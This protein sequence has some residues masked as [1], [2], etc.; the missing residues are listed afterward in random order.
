MATRSRRVEYVFDQRTTTLATATRLDHATETITIAETASRVFK[1]VIVDVRAS[2]NNA[3]VAATTACLIGIKLAAV[4]FD[5]VTYT[6]GNG[7]TADGYSMQYTRDVTSYFTT[8]FGSGTTQTCQVGTT[9]TGSGTIN[10]TVKLIITYEFD[11]SSATTRTKTVKIPLE[12]GLGALTTTLAEV[13]T[14]QVP[15]L[16]TFLP[17]AS[18]TVKSLWFEV[19]SNH[20]AGGTTDANLAL[21]LDAEAEASMG[22]NEMAGQ[23]GRWMRHVW[24]RNDMTLNATHAFKARTTNTHCPYTCL[25]VLLCVTYTYDHST[26]TT[27]L[28]SVEIACGNGGGIGW[29]SSAELTTLATTFWVEEPATITL[30][31]SG[32]LATFYSYNA[33]TA[34]NFACGG[35]TLR[36]FTPSNG[37][38]SNSPMNF[39]QRVDSGS[40]SGAGL[41]LARGENTL[42]TKFYTT[43]QYDQPAGNFGGTLYLNYTSG[44]HASGDGVHNH[45]ITYH[46]AS[47]AAGNVGTNYS[48]WSITPNIPEASYWLTNVGLYVN[49]QQYNSPSGCDIEVETLTTDL[50]G[51]LG[52]RPILNT[53]TYAEYSDIEQI[54]TIDITSHWRSSP[55]QLLQPKGLNIESARDWRIFAV[56]GIGGSA[57]M[58]L[59]ITYHSITYTVAGS[60]SS[61]AGDGSGIVA[62]VYDAVTHGALAS[63]TTVAGGAYSFTVY[64]DVNGAYVVCRENNTHVGRSANGT[65]T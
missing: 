52:Q 29:Y 14:N 12:S 39:L 63:M 34:A 32:V 11:D 46:I 58:S 60:A 1:S 42:T 64:D 36:A 59:N 53:T 18:V 2:E 55:T 19:L 44:L 26:T 10:I 5:D 3:S 20:G 40:T 33:P 6:V 13:G 47:L 65:P 45:T 41:T 4:A 57:V 28:N 35:Q 7:G 50:I 9:F 43:G 22:V 37:P 56:G 16:D 61:Y 31:Q 62:V 15:Q 48:S 25:S 51:V 38:N 17:E 49:L 30:V 8:N 54:E 21:S 24:R 27:V 23:D